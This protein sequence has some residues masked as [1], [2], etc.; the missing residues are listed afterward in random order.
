M[1][2]CWIRTL[3]IVA[4][5]VILIFYRESFWVDMLIYAY[6]MVGAWQL[7]SMVVHVY[8]GYFMR[9][10][11]AR[12]I[13]QWIS[14]ISL[15]TIPLGSFGILIFIAPFMAVFYTALCYVETYKKMK[16]PMELLK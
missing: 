8:T 6:I 13:Y 1:A 14:F 4:S 2:D 9:I 7:I 12:F 3:L 5:F 11:G 10:Y 16:R 15:I